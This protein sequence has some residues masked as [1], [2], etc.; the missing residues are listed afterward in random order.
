MYTI[1]FVFPRKYANVSDINRNDSLT[2]FL[3]LYSLVM[4]WFHHPIECHT[5]HVYKVSLSLSLSVLLCL[6]LFL[7]IASYFFVS[8]FLSR[9]SLVHKITVAKFIST[10]VAHWLKDLK[11]P[12]NHRTIWHYK[13]FR[14]LVKQCW[15]KCAE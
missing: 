5:I 6:S 7:R 4:C 3:L 9:P 1:W 8:L 13:Q 2:L 14:A 15:Q 10:R 12:S 11:K